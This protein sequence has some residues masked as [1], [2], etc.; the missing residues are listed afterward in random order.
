MF[1]HTEPQM[2][3]IVIIEDEDNL[4]FSLVQSLKKVG[5]AII[6]TD[7]VQPAY[8]IIRDHEP[9]LVLTDINLQ[10]ESGL[11]LAS[12]IRDEGFNGAIIVM[13]AYG[14]VESAIE[15]M[16]NGADEY[17][18][19]PLSLEELKVL[20]TRSLENR[21]VRSEL[22]LYRR[23]ES[24]RR[25]QNK[26][27]GESESWNQTVGLA[28]RMASLPIGSGEVLSAILLLGETGSGKGMLARYIH[29]IS[30]QKEAPFVH[31]NCS[32]IPA[33]LIE[34]ELFGHEKGAFTD[35]RS[36]RQGLFEL[37]DGGTIFLDEIG[38][39]PLELQSKLLLVV[40]H[41]ILRRIGGSK[42]R[43]VNA[44][45]IAATNQDIESL[46]N[47]GKFRRDLFYRLNALTIQIPPLR[48]RNGDVL[49]IAESLLSSVSN[50]MH[51]PGLSFGDDALDAMK[52]HTWPGNVRELAN[53]IHRA[54]LLSKSET[55]SADD[56][57]LA[58]GG[59]P[60]RAL[61]ASASAQARASSNSASSADELAFD[62]SNG[63]L[64]AEAVERELIVQALRHARGNVSRAAKLI[65]MNRSSLR[66]RI[67]RYD[68]DEFV[69]EL[70]TK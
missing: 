16:K 28:E 19:K 25:E 12:R 47:D 27:L 48:G 31:I 70:A 61:G 46:A 56:L 64:T 68:L 34:G 10:G 36:A 3:K 11:D 23:L 15:A 54:A 14:S 63:A 32:A 53:A 13:T 24:S 49:L 51:R 4:R 21:K 55:I 2:A 62:F 59:I 65:G 58:R 57:G 29:D 18:Q 69:Q 30:P 35:A 50:Q 6:E 8:E 5:H 39:M 33:T 67:E 43:K 26:L 41:G 42:E 22:N 66:Y 17:L 52:E 20:V 7:A 60:G 38:D 44:R 37:A 1:G 40:E 45:V 9:D